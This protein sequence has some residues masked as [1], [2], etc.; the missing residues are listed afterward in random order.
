MEHMLSES[1]EET[2]LGTLVGELG[3]NEGVDV[4]RCA[5]LSSGAK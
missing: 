5:G 2:G 4:L 1:L 3:G